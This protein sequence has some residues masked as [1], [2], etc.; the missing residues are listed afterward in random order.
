[1]AAD[2]SSR[3]AFVASVVDFLQTYNFD[4]LD[5]DWEY[6]AER[7]GQTVDKVNRVISFG[8]IVLWY[9]GN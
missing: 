4:G 1:M 6:P 9:K 7:G 5:L 8:V 2:A 3:Q